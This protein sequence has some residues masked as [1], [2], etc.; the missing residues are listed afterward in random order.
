M[1]KAISTDIVLNKEQPWIFVSFEYFLKLYIQCLF[2]FESIVSTNNVI[3]I[4]K[5]FCIH[6][7]SKNGWFIIWKNKCKHGVVPAGYDYYLG[8][9]WV[10][11]ESHLHCFSRKC[12]SSWF[13]NLRQ[14]Q[15]PPYIYS[16]TTCVQGGGM[17]A[18]V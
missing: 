12:Y 14:R 10:I 8:T 7:V 15:S 13:V 3:L 17:T 16:K 4:T 6:A 2:C 5:N 18:S 9:E 1:I 11:T